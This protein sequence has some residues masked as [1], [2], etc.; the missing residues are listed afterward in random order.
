MDKRILDE[1]TKLFLEQH[2]QNYTGLFFHPEEEGNLKVNDSLTEIAND[3]N[4]IDN[5]L[6]E[7]GANINYLLTNSVNRLAEV[8]RCIISEKERYQDI[9]MLCNK[10]TDFDSVKEL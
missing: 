7:T 9:Q 8:K 4:N 3:I 1:Y 5:I 2:K 10:Y 6:I